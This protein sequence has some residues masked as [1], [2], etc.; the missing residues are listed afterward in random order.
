MFNVPSPFID[1]YEIIFNILLLS[2]KLR[3]KMLQNDCDF[4]PDPVN[5][6]YSQIIGLML[7][8]RS[9]YNFLIK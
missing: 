7:Q 5:L 8:R 2:R 9:K 4:K 6:F 3:F 1:K